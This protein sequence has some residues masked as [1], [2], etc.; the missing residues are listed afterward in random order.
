MIDLLP[1]ATYTFLMS[2][3]PGPNNV[4]VTA[5]AVAFGYR[6]TL[7]HLLGIGFGCAFQTALIC[8]GLGTIFEQV[9]VLHDAL[10]WIGAAYLVYLAWCLLRA[11]QV[12]GDGDPRARPLRFFEAVAFQFLNPKAW[13]MAIT[14]ASVFLPREIEPVL[15]SLYVGVVM[16][17]VNFPSVSVWALFGSAMR[18][19]LSEPR[20]RRAF[21][22]VLAAA[23][24]ITGAAMLQP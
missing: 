20:W 11:G 3:T 12:D 13:V 14:I 22:W 2:I 6:R 5:S 8:L 23:L 19:L 10:R 16:A 24:V 21:N 9:P 4:L 1:L 18:R 17:I 7:P 15:G